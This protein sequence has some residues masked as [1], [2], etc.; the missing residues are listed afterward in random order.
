METLDKVQPFT[1]LALYFA[2]AV[3]LLTLVLDSILE[4]RPPGAYALACVTASVILATP[5]LIFNAIS[6]K[7][8]ASEQRAILAR[9][10][11]IGSAIVFIVGLIMLII[12]A[13]ITGHAR[14]YYS[15]DWLAALIALVGIIMLGFGSIG[16]TCAF[17]FGIGAPTVPSTSKFSF[18]ALVQAWKG[19]DDGERRWFI[20][21]SLFITGTL[22][23]FF[24]L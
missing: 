20:A 21:G 11:G 16:L 9:N 18:H 15:S 6:R 12:H 7:V 19:V 22:I 1:S 5:N 2:A 17:V 24:S 10:V 4:H 8:V 14:I 23:Q 3:A 13:I